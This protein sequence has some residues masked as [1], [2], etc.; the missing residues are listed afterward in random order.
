MPAIWNVGNTNGYSEKKISSKLTFEEGETFKGR[1]VGKG[2]GEG[3]LIKLIDG[4][5]FSADLLDESTTEGQQLLQFKVEGFEDGKI[6]LKIITDSQQKEEIIEDD[7]VKDFISKEG[8]S[9]D[10]FTLLKAMTK[11]NIPL[12]KDNIDFVKSVFNLSQKL[13]NKV[14]IDEFINNYISGKGI[15]PQTPEAAAIRNTLNEFF[16]AFETMNQEDILLFLENGIDINK[17]NIDSYNKLFKGD[18]T[19]KEQLDNVL[20]EF[21]SLD[22][23]EV[24]ISNK[25]NSETEIGKEVNPKS[26]NNEEVAKY[27]QK[28]TMGLKIYDDTTSSKSRVSLLNLLKAMRGENTN[29]THDTVKD[30]LVGNR[31]GFKA[32]ELQQ[33]FTKLNSMSEKEL[34]NNLKEAID[35]KTIN[36][37]SLENALRDI[38]GKDMKISESETNKLKD[39]LYSNSNTTENTE[40]TEQFSKEQGQTSNKLTGT[41]I[42]DNSESQKG[43][44]IQKTIIKEGKA[45]EKNPLSQTGKTTSSMVVKNEFNGKINDMK[46]VIRHLLTQSEELTDK[47]LEGKLSEFIKSNINDFKLFNAL[48]N[49]YY[50]LDIPISRENADYPCKLIIKDDRKGNKRIDSS[51]VK[52]VVAVKTVNMGTVDAYI[53][54]LDNNLTVDIKCIDKYMKLLSKGTNQLSEKLSSLGYFVNINVHEKIEEV[55]LTTCREFF[56][57]GSNSALDTKV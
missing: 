25:P 28:Q 21:K 30:I 4:W 41:I 18:V 50:Y 32:S 13:G 38:F 10:D 48:S 22:L 6:K 36:K 3:V 35:G 37:E 34:Q 40:Q 29:L 14:E 19:I 57:S 33:S 27:S 49:E 53:S 24:V 44:E 26:I 7:A 9:K 15:D 8:I 56:N 1:I 47:T 43:N 12:F 16:A 45:E 17:E 51:N 23:E 2:E 46:D 39:I 20:K 52:M 55:G 42:K 31:D 11:F 5:Q 54:V